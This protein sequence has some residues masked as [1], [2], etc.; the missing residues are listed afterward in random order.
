[1]RK[2]TKVF[3]LIAIMALLLTCFAGCK[4]EA[5]GGKVYTIVSDNAFAP[6]E[7]YD[8]ETGEYVGIDMD[9]MAAIAEDQG[10]QYN[11]MNVGFD[12]ALA[13]VQANQADAVIAGM[14]INEDR[15]LIFDFSEG[16]FED[17]QVLVVAADS[18]IKSVEDLKGKV[19]A[20]KNGTMGAEYANAN[21]DKYGYTTKAFEGSNEQYQAIL[22]GNCVACFED[23][24]V[25]GDAIKNG[26]KLKT[27]GDK[28]NP[29]YYGFAVKKGQNAELIEK[30]NAGLKNIKENGK[31]DEILAKYGL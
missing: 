5:A 9:I 28:I 11:M 27:I 29:S 10:I 20:T 13:K 3:A 31:Y 16:Y 1:M 22:N 7:S 4:E 25:I 24:T 30:F 8:S 19:V 6:F 14:T 15:K 21:K 12:P 26:I 2:F 23:Y 17:G 18:D